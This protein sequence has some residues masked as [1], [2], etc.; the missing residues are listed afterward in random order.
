V[1][2][3]EKKLLEEFFTD[4]SFEEL[5]K[6]IYGER[7]P[8]LEKKPLKELEIEQEQEEAHESPLKIEQEEAS[9][10]SFEIDQD[11]M[12]EAS[13]EYPEEE[14]IEFLHNLQNK[15][16]ETPVDRD[17]AIEESLEYKEKQ[18]ILETLL[19]HLEKDNDLNIL[20][21]KEPDNTEKALDNLKHH[22]PTQEFIKEGDEE[23]PSCSYHYNQVNSM[24]SIQEALH[25]V[26]ERNR[27]IPDVEVIIVKPAFSVLMEYHS[28]TASHGGFLGVQGDY[29]KY[30]LLLG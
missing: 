7:K 16:N 20:M 1:S 17:E 5:E 11:D 26:I 25:D 3:S 6:E 22:R 23:T 8:S 18:Q 4:K 24:E 10:P 27:M 14:Y 29:V 12:N 9:E 2:S 15:P 30:V 13:F 19:E 21:I 28:K